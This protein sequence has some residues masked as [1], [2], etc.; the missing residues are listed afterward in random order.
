MWMPGLAAVIA[1][2]IF[3]RNIRGLGCGVGKPKYY[4]IT[5]LLPILYAAI[6]YGVV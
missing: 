1:T 2:F 5:Y 4:L 6:A 3:Q